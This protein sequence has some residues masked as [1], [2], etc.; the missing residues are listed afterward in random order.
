MGLFFEA[1]DN[2]YYSILSFLLNVVI[3]GT[4]YKKVE[5]NQH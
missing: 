5:L 2:V 3:I 4:K 1:C